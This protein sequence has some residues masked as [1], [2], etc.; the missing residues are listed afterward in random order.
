MSRKTRGSNRYNKQKLKVSRIHQDTK[1]QREWYIHNI[2]SLLVN[3]FDLIAIEDLNV[4]GI[5]SRF[6]KSVS[7]ASFSTLVNQ[8]IYKS[9]RNGVALRKVDRFYPSSKACSQCGNVKSE[10]L[11]SERVY[12]CEECNMSMDRDLNASKNILSSVLEEMK[13]ELN[14]EEH[15]E[16]SRGEEISLEEVCKYPLI[17]SSMKRLK[18]I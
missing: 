15:P 11:L 9:Q 17:A 8:L 18:T 1:N 6:G 16:Y 12:C 10:L 5:K 4:E 2:T 13:N 3:N 7:D 14:S